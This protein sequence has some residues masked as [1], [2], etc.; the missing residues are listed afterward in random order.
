MALPD[1]LPGL[2]EFDLPGLSNT[3]PT[4]A[5]QPQPSASYY[6]TGISDRQG[7]YVN[8][9]DTEP[10]VTEIPGVDR[11][12]LDAN[13]SDVGFARVQPSPMTVEERVTADSIP[14]FDEVASPQ[15]QD[16]LIGGS[17][18]DSKESRRD[19]K[20]REKGQVKPHK[21]RRS[22]IDD[23][24]MIEPIGGKQAKKV[25]KRKNRGAAAKVVQGTVITLILGV[26]G[27][28]TY[29]AVMPPETLTEDDVV[30]V[31]EQRTG[32]YED[33]P[34]EK[35]EGFARDFIEAYVTTPNDPAILG[36]FY[37]GNFRESEAAT[38]IA[39]QEYIQKVVIGPTVYETVP[40]SAKS[41]SITV[42]V[43]VSISSTDR[44][45]ADG[46]T[47]KPPTLAWQ[48]FNVNVYYDIDT[49]KMHIAPESPTVVTPTEIG[50]TRDVPPAA[51][52]GEKGET[53][54]ALAKEL[55]PVVQ[56]FIKAYATSSTENHQDLDQYLVSKPDVH[57]K[58]G[59][60]GQYAFAGDPQNAI[61]HTAYPDGE[62]KAK[63]LAKVT[64]E[65][66][67][68]GNDKAKIA[69][70]SSYVITLEKEG[71][72]WLVSKFKPYRYAPD[73][74]AKVE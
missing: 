29:N 54:E 65:S 49:E 11:S 70:Q 2:D 69:Y 62:G 58:N 3:P 46:V 22:F 53:D 4:P 27:V 16:Q 39:S 61:T 8:P 33:F 44:I 15:R 31:V 41:A 7:G 9:Y 57:L 51:P 64:W 68:S 10:V 6:A 50:Q 38:R 18:H 12:H 63:V 73:P 19:R 23:E 67:D 5:P 37:S 36:Y 13:P 72:K 1:D 59:L 14:S 55:A 24:G 34:R 56:G 66:V 47:E 71:S 52:L 45:Q 35:A 28:G 43:L 74:N 20:K 17:A 21:Q 30:S 32:L 25:D 48:Y 26:I 40:L 60:D 42:G